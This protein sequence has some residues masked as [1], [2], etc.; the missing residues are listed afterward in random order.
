MIIVFAGTSDAREY[1]A[2]LAQR[3]E[4]LVVCTATAYGA[5]LIAPHK[6][7]VEISGNSLDKKGIAQLVAS[8]KADSVVDATHPYALEVSL[9]IR[10]TCDQLGVPLERRVREGFLEKSE[11][12]EFADDYTSAAKALA[13]T[14]GKILLTIG[15]RRLEPFAKNIE[16]SRMIIRVLPTAKVLAHC[17]SLGFAPAQII[18]MQGPFSQELNDSIYEDYDIVHM[19]TKD[20]GK[21][22][23]VAQKVLPAIERGIHVVVIKRPEED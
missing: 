23:G 11:D 22:G 14:S 18:A 21:Q 16:I 4:K 6:N 7:I 3:G 10:A 17:E 8:R 9:N 19:V 20:S 12:L 1:V 15:S 2:Q 5:S 13:N